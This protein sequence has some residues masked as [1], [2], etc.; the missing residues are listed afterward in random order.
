M[1]SP[2][3]A[4]TITPVLKGESAT[5]LNVSYT[6]TGVALKADSALCRLPKILFGMTASEVTDDGIVAEDDAGPLLLEHKYEDPTPSATFRRWVPGR[7]TEGAI[8]VSYFAPVRIVDAASTNG[9]LYDMRAEGSGLSA[10]GLTF[11]AFPELD[12]TFDATVEWDLS[13]SPD[14]HRGVSSHGEGTVHRQATLEAIASTFYMAGPIQS[15]IDDPSSVFN[16]YW[17]SETSFDP[18]GVGDS[19][20]EMYDYMC[21]YF[22]EPNPGYRVFVRK[23]EYAGSGGSAMLGSRGFMFGWSEQLPQTTEDLTSLLAH[24]M[25]HNWP[26]LDPNDD[27][28]EWSWYAEGAAEY[29]SILLRH[30]A[31]QISAEALAEKL[32]QCAHGYYGNPLQSLS[33]TEAAALYWTD[34]RAQKVPYNRGLY[35]L[36][37]TDHRIRTVT[38][39]ARSVD[40]IVLEILVRQRNGK[41]VTVADWVELVTVE[42]GD[43][44]IHQYEAMVAGELIYP[45]LA[46]L[47]PVLS[48]R[49]APIRQLDIG[50]D[51]SSLRNGVVS[52]LVPGGSAE[53]VGLREGD[54]IVDGPLPTRLVAKEAGPLTLRVR[55]GEREFNYTYEPY[56]DTIEG[57]LWAP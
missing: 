4:I 29:Y 48:G 42:L 31:G 5:G 43:D 8:R 35:Y 34:W 3:I 27:P 39:G 28:A 6:M 22:H 52:G 23:Y 47:S 54:E 7:D 33:N 55:R 38:N 37:D 36:I 18:I 44:A 20:A 49:Q 32:N 2:S 13:V 53:R 9:P 19:I 24:E 57:V 30:S 1:T 15:Y 26:L 17:L 25:T 10:A 51:F 40:D 46:A 14:S 56:G 11:L 12:D 45:D 16:M 50:M 41:R 21:K